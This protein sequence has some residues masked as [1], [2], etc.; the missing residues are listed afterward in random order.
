MKPNTIQFFS[1][2]KRDESG[3]VLR[4]NATCRSCKNALDRDRYAASPE[5][6]RKRQ[7]RYDRWFAR[8]TERRATDPEYDRAWRERRAGYA[9]DAAER[10]QADWDTPEEQASYAEGPEMPAGPLISALDA[11]RDREK[12]TDAAV[13]TAIGID[14]RRLREWRS[15]RAQSVRMSIADAALVAMDLLWW[16]CWPEG[17]FPEVAAI[18]EGE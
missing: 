9:R 13:A 15:G 18:W 3:G 4:F 14:D 17:D 5:E 10:L 8:H 2:Q 1:V 6:R 7:A 11:W 16:E 12:M